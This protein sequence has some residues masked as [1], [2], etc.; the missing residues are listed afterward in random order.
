MQTRLWKRWSWVVCLALCAFRLQAQEITPLRGPYLH[1]LLDDSV[2]VLWAS[3]A[4]YAGVVRW[5]APDGAEGVVTESAATTSHVVKLSGLQPSTTYSYEVLAVDDLIAEGDAFRFRT[6][7]P[8]GTGTVRAVVVGDSGQPA[9]PF[10]AQ[11]TSMVEQLDPDLFLHTGDMTYTGELGV[12]VFE[13]YRQ[14]LSTR[15]VYAARGNHDLAIGDASAWLELFPPPNQITRIEACVV[16]TA[17]CADGNLPERELPLPRESAFYSFDWGPVHFASFD[18]NRDVDGCGAQV[19]WLCNDL[20]SARERGM[21]WLVL[22]SHHPVYSK[23]LHGFLES[24]TLRLFPAIAEKYGVDLVI[25]GH[26]HNYQR[27][28]PIRGGEIVDAWQEPNYDHPE[29]PIYV[30]TGGGGAILYGLLQQAPRKAL[31]KVFHSTYHATEVEFSPER[32]HLRAVDLDGA[33]LDDVTVTKGAARTVAGFRRGDLTFDGRHDLSDG[34]QV[35]NVLFLGVGFDCTPAFS[36]VGDSDGNGRAELADAI[37]LFNYLF[38]GGPV[39][40]PP[41]PACEA[42]PEIDVSSCEQVG[43]RF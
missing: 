28:C 26:D 25:S 23:G 18:G 30:V 2:Q 12:P 43:C 17:L 3:E 14:L 4:S 13:H 33:V 19:Q 37:Y 36:F 8:S 31:V 9:L 21:P 27:T 29:G 16:P 5:R 38:L 22:L 34:V 15:G 1:G 40:A 32:L 39:L 42:T 7:P 41:F 10:L 35:L 24:A 20:R 6:A 11:V